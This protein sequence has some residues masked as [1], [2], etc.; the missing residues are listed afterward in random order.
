MMELILVFAHGDDR[1]RVTLLKGSRANPNSEAD[2]FSDYDIANLVSDVEPFRD[3]SRIASIFGPVMIMQT[4]EDKEWPSPAGDGRYNYNMQLADGNRIDLSFFHIDRAEEIAQDSLTIVLLDK[5]DLLPDLPPAGES[6]YFVVEPTPRL[7][8][9]CCNEFFFGLGSHVP[10]TLWRRDLPL[11][12]RYMDVVLR[13]PLVMMLGWEAGFESD[14][15][16]SIGKAGGRLKDYL[17]G[18]DWEMFL[19]TYPDSD[20]EKICDSLKLLYSM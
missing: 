20:I 7:Y 3:R 1:I 19:R 2:I 9:D 5:D 6:S 4:P 18:D 11:L 10:K 16:I 13:R 14:F 15:R 17:S 8:T 12:H